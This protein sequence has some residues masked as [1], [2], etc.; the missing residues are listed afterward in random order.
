M[1][2][3]RVLCSE[4]HQPAAD[5]PCPTGPAEPPPPAYPAGTDVHVYVTPHIV[6]ARLHNHVATVHGGGE[7]LGGR[8]ETTGLSMIRFPDGSVAFV[9][10]SGKNI[11]P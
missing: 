6:M 9:L 4:C 8:V 3:P 11:R 1:E 10:D 7:W 2:T 5:H